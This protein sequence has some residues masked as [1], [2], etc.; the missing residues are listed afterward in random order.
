[1]PNAAVHRVKGRSGVWVVEAGK[2][3]FQP[4]TTGAT[5]LNGTVQVLGGL[6]QGARIVAYS[7]RSLT[8]RTRI[9]VVDQIAGGG[10]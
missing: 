4:V 9:R 10:Q 1:M 8:A 7:Q 6:N 3:R 2:L 5:D